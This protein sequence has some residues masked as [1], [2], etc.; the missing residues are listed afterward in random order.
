MVVAAAVSVI[1]DF[2]RERTGAGPALE[3]EFALIERRLDQA[4]PMR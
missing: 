1:D 4:S 2:T 3:D